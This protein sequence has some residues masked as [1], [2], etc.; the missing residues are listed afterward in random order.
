[1]NHHRLRESIAAQRVT[2]LT[3]I[4]EGA[5]SIPGLA[6]WV[7]GP[8]LPEAVVQASSCSSDSTPLTWKLPHP[9]GAALKK[10]KEKSDQT[11]EEIPI[12]RVRSFSLGLLRGKGRYHPMPVRMFGTRAFSL[13]V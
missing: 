5:G 12:E 2:N 3:H 13:L 9:A 4:H 7:K 10:Q 6:Q 1:M 8:V 11:P